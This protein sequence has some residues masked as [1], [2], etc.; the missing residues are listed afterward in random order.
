[1]TSSVR[2]TFIGTI[3]SLLL[4]SS[5]QAAVF[6]ATPNST[7]FKS[8]II[9]PTSSLIYNDSI[10]N[11][12]TV[13]LVP[14]NTASSASQMLTISENTALTNI[15]P[16]S[17]SSL[18]ILPT[19]ATVYTV[20]A[21]GNTQNSGNQPF[22]GEASLVK[23]GTGTYTL[24][25]AGN[26]YTGP[27]TINSGTLKLAQPMASS[28]NITVNQGGTL[29][30]AMGNVF[31][32]ADNKVKVTVN[33]GTINSSVNGHFN[34]GDVV[35]NGGKITSTG[36][37]SDFGNVLMSG[38]VR[39]TD[40]AT[41]DAQKILI[42]HNG[43]DYNPKSGDFIVDSGKTLTINSIINFGEVNDTAG[44]K[45]PVSW[46]VSGGG[47][48][49]LTKAVTGMGSHVSISVTGAGTMLDL[50]VE[51]TL[52][53]DEIQNVTITVADGAKLNSSAATHV[54]VGNIVLA[55]GSLTSEGSSNS[56]QY[57]NFLI[58]GKIT[59][60]QD[61]S[62]TASRIFFRNP[63][64]N[65]NA[66]IIELQ[67]GSTLT[68][69]TILDFM[70]NREPY[71]EN[72][73]LTIKGD[74]TVIVPSTGG[75]SDM[76]PAK[77]SVTIS[78]PKA[79]LQYGAGDDK[80]GSWNL[81]VTLEKGGTLAFNRNNT[82]GNIS[83]NIYA[84][85]GTVKNL[86]TTT[87]VY[88]YAIHVTDVAP[89]E[90]E[91]A[92]PGLTFSTEGGNIQINT[93]KL[94]GTGT[95]VKEGEKT[96]VLAGANANYSG[97]TILKE[98]VLDIRN[99]GSLGTGDLVLDGGTLMNSASEIH[100]SKNIDIEVRSDSTIASNGG[101]LKLLGNMTGS[102]TITKTGNGQ[103]HFQGDNSVFAGTVILKQS[104]LGFNYNT[105]DGS[106]KGS[107]ALARYILDNGT[108]GEGVVFVPKT[109]TDVFEM[110]ML[111][112]NNKFATVRPGG[113][114]TNEGRTVV[115][116]QVGGADMSG[117]FA[118]I[119]ADNAYNINN[120]WVTTRLNV[121][122]VGTGTWTWTNDTVKA[123]GDLK[124][125][126]GTLQL[127][128]GDGKATGVMNSFGSV[129]V[130][131]DGTLAV[132]RT[133]G[134]NYDVNQKITFN[135]GTLLQ[136][137]SDKIVL[138]GEI[139]GSEMVIDATESAT[140]AVFFQKMGTTMA[141]VNV[142][143]VTIKGGTVIAKADISTP[144][145][146]DIQGGT[147]ELG[148]QDTST[149]IDSPIRIATDGTLKVVNAAS[150]VT[151]I[152]FAG[153]TFAQPSNNLD[154][155]NV[156]VEENTSSTMNFTD[157]ASE[158]QVYVKKTLTGSG[159]LTLAGNG[160][161]GTQL[162]I[163]GDGSQ[164]TGTIV[165]K[166]N[167]FLG[168]NGSQASSASGKYVADNGNFYL[169]SAAGK[170]GV[171]ELGELSGNGGEI[172]ASVNNAVKNLEIQVGGL[173]TDATYGG[174]I[175]N[176]GDNVIGVTKV[177]TG[178][179]TLTSKE[180]TYTGGTRVEAGTLNVAGTLNSDFTVKGG[181]LN[182]ANGGSITSTKDVVVNNGGMLQLSGGTIDANVHIESGA[183]MGGVGHV[184]GRLLFD[185]GAMYTINL[186]N[187]DVYNAVIQNKQ[188][189]TV[190]DGITTTDGLML[191]IIVDDTFFDDPEAIYEF[192]VLA[193]SEGGM[194]LEALE[195]A[196]N[197][198]DAVGTWFW[199][200]DEDGDIYLMGTMSD[201]A[202]PEPS[203]MLLLLLASAGLVVM[204]KRRKKS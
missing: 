191:K 159:T 194:S 69:G 50:G 48:V 55:G 34:L 162:Q 81:P 96:L 116:I 21:D 58:R 174:K 160:S 107:S 41:I 103:L 122:K 40:N 82:M 83:F 3:I 54:N 185:K 87:N 126:E 135:G 146:I 18:T 27:T 56:S 16:V 147:L 43:G 38:E 30:I 19:G 112:T 132:N 195:I 187:K 5:T 118:G 188:P 190:A 17:L 201:M 11:G 62:I 204:K 197:T 91:E 8:G 100:L 1:M 93:D 68:L 144:S 175:L 101:D 166:N 99:N 149:K 148:N 39:V 133:H 199:G 37:A 145:L 176:N 202:V 47:T 61:S 150:K 136:M 154:I 89:A 141:K 77:N 102:G 108:S 130:E 113:N 92:L 45:L 63:A 85:G 79:V 46:D 28:K 139:V 111:E 31:G 13:A 51:N 203:T 23:E 20:Y 64:N 60:T 115:N 24:N 151:D 156:V 131:K 196:L 4:A 120:E 142:D 73:K 181:T 125:T 9:N 33:G 186:T 94:H 80:G 14:V 76:D 110:G 128:V 49:K 124:I 129:T 36:K 74:G 75:L 180:H 192:E 106:T 22:T 119:F 183:F 6:T 2:K 117:T 95:V 71:N 90:G 25:N 7:T 26:N 98:G 86:G 164:F 167:A 182:V 165:V 35:L 161:A 153:G 184:S 177:G 88:G 168:F 104:W 189:L 140:G 32:L 169:Y 78:G 72:A 179:W 29:D 66:G 127:G 172:R 123:T 121:E 200:K 170:S 53:I 134:L 163:H 157:P 193:S 44:K 152:T 143:K 15:V 65:P 155:Q 52:G 12:G 173:N 171:Y 42:R 84:N 57:G 158:R 70:G 10:I 105:D 198:E 109:D 178:T 67:N 97:T 59:V 137:G 138:N 114:A